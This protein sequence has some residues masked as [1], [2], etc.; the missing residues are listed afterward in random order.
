[1][2]FYAGERVLSLVLGVLASTAQ[3]IVILAHRIAPASMLAPFFYSQLIWVTGLGFVVFGNVPDEWTLIGAG[4]I[5]ASGVYTVHRERVRR[6][7]PEVP[8]V[9]PRLPAVAKPAAGV[10]DT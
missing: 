3:W 1:L 10:A 6:T 9:P 4:I 2:L 7:M 5:V 8:R